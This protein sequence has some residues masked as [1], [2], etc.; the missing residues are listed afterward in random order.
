M[1]YCYQQFKYVKNA[2]KRKHPKTMLPS[3]CFWL[4]PRE[5]QL[6]MTQSKSINPNPKNSVLYYTR[7]CD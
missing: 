4:C 5:Q 2:F 7:G 6:A 3:V 1:H